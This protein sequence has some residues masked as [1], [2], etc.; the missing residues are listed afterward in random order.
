[1][2]RA[3][4]YL[5]GLAETRA[6]VAG[7]IQRLLKAQRDLI[8][9]MNLL[10]QRLKQCE[11]QLIAINKLLPLRQEELHA[12]DR[13]IIDFNS[14][15][16]PA[17]IKPVQSW[18]GRYGKRGW[19]RETVVQALTKAYPQALTSHEIEKEVRAVHQLVFLSPQHRK[20]W[21]HNSLRGA[22]KVLTAKGLVERMHQPVSCSAGRGRW[23]WKPPAGAQT[24]VELS[25]LAEAAGIGTWQAP[26]E[27]PEEA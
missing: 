20:D 1:M 10:H 11:H 17:L 27:A 26:D 24:L 15:V 16:S 6:R 8:E 18:Q 7:D 13:L 4:P 12:C 25:A 22:L 5:K 2:S 3:H 23:R 21:F 9:K 19:L 14:R